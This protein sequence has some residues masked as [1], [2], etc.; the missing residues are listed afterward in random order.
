MP[1]PVARYIITE[2]SRYFN[3]SFGGKIV[4]TLIRPLVL[5]RKG[6][7]ELVSCSGECL[8]LWENWPM[9]KQVTKAL[10]DAGFQG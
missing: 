2:D 7:W 1:A 3:V 8:G 9:R 4:A 10:I 6:N 5:D